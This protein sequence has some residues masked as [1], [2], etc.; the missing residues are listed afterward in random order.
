MESILLIVVVLVLGFVALAFFLRQQLAKQQQLQPDQ[1]EQMVNQVFGKTASSIA[2]QS[3]QILASEKQVIQTDLSNKHAMIEN[4]VKTIQQEMTTRQ[5]ELRTLEQDRI[6]KFAEMAG[7][8]DSHRQLTEKLQ[9]STD[10]LSKVLSNNQM[11]GSW[12]EKILEELLKSNGLV[13]NIHYL[14]Q[15]KQSETGLKP[16]ITLLLPDKRQV[17]IDVKFPYAAIQK[18]ADSDTKE[19]RNLQM[20]QFASDVKIKIDK[21]AEYIRPDQDTLDYAILFV[22][23]EMIFSFINQQ[24]PE[25]VDQAISKRVLL[26]SPFTFLI[27]ARTILESYRN[28]E[29]EDKLRDI[30]KTISEFTH[31]W[32]KFQDEFQKFGRAVDAVSSGYDQLRKTRSNQLERK[33]HK[34]EEYQKGTSSLTEGT[35]QKMLDPVE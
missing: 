19:S 27:V 17:P 29:I 11:R 18:L 23:N 26:V 22:P 35:S 28:F 7:V 24:F 8:L 2:E 3:R 12:G 16:D 30:L 14:R 31:E 34:I 32:G 15:Q 5:G 33:I 6:K 10:Q 9:I 13:E 20:K 1:L 25:L 4:L 21:V